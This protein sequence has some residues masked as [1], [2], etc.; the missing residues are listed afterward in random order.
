MPNVEEHT[1]SLWKSLEKR[2]LFVACSGGVDSMV[3]LDLLV[4]LKYSVT[5]IHVNYQLRGTASDDD[6]ALVRQVCTS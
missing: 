3:L 2:T 6:E 4:K 5:V 1:R